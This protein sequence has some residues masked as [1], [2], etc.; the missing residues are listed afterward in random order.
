LWL[1]DN[2][3]QPLT[4]GLAYALVAALVTGST[5]V[6]MRRVPVWRD[7]ATL[8]DETAREDPTD[9]VVVNAAGTALYHVGQ[10]PRAFALFERA[11]AL[12]PGESYTHNSLGGA[13]FAFHRYDDALREFQKAVALSPDTGNYWRNLGVAYANKS[14]WP[15]AVDAFR[16]SIERFRASAPPVLTAD[17]KSTL[18]SLYV[19]Y[20]TALLRE[21]EAKLALDAFQ[22]AVKVDPADFDARM[23]LGEALLQQG[24]LDAAASQIEQGLHSQP[25]SPQA[26]LAHFYLGRIYRQKGMLEAANQETQKALELNPTMGGQPLG[27]SSLRL[28]VPAQG[29]NP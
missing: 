10:Y 12:A 11:L 21:G 13:Y 15:E 28:V 25:G 7:S 26:Y 5:T 24:Q 16:H 17:L 4:R 14:M 6:V 2:A 8:W 18:T 27:A 19:Q 3:N 1:L 23:R 20:G 9:P 22:N 29:K